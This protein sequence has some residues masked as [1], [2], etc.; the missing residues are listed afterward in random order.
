MSLP[1]FLDFVIVDIIL[2]LKVIYLMHD[3]VVVAW[4]KPLAINCSVS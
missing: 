2:S 4:C 3:N 1:A